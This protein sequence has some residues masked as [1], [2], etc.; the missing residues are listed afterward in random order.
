[1]GERIFQAKE[2]ILEDTGIRSKIAYAVSHSPELVTNKGKS[3]SQEMRHFMIIVM[4]IT[5]GLTQGVLLE[6]LGQIYHMIKF[7]FYK[8]TLHAL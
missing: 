2:D 4:S 5:E 1:M 8:I 6:D 7:M 3:E